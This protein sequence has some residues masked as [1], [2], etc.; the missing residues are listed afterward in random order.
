MKT[1][2]VFLHALAAAG[3]GVALLAAQV[4]EARAD[5]DVHHDR[6]RDGGRPYYWHESRRLPRVAIRLTVGG[7]PY[8][9]CEGDYYRYGPRGYV[10]VPAPVG[11]VVTTLPEPHQTVIIN[12]VVYHYDNGVYYQQG[13]GGYVVVPA[14][15]LAVAAATPAPSSLV[16]NVPNKNGSFTPVTLQSASNGMFIGPQGEVYPNPPTAEQLKDLYG[17]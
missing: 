2:V 17:Q 6:H 10:I 3:V 1:R 9:Y 4:G 13:P 15:P 5:W 11:A 16:I 7:F 8:Y 14:T 12:G